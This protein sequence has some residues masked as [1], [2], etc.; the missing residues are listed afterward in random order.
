MK[1]YYLIEWFSQWCSTYILYILQRMRLRAVSADDISANVNGWVILIPPNHSELIRSRIYPRICVPTFRFR[2]CSSL[3]VQRSKHSLFD[4][5][6]VGVFS[7]REWPPERVPHSAL[8]K[9]MIITT[10][11]LASG[12]NEA[13][14]RAGVF[15]ALKI[16]YRFQTAS[17]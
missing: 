6:E 12:E 1:N 11:K 14:I 15:Q 13:I 8:S 9:L 7:L 16:F 3:H 2:W 17:C 10:S 4:G 5:E